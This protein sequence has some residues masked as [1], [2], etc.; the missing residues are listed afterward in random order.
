MNNMFKSLKEKLSKFFKSP[1]EKEKKVEEPV[2]KE[3]KEIKEEKV[4]EKKEPEKPVE[5]PKEEKETEEKEVKE[6]EVEEPIADKKEEKPKE[7]KEPIKETKEEVKLKEQTIEEKAQK[8]EEIKEELKQENTEE[9]EHAIEDIEKV[10]VTVKPTFFEKLRGRLGSVKLD[11]ETFNEFFEELETLLIENNVAL[12]VIDQIRND[13]EKDLVDIEIKKSEIGNEIKKFLKE[14]ISNILLEPFDIISKIKEKKDD[15]YVILFFGIN[16]S[17]KTTTISK[18]AH[19][20]KEHKISCVFAAGDTFRAASIE[21][22]AKHGENL[23]IKVISQ[24]YGTDPAAVAFDAVKY[25]KAHG[26]KAVLVDTAGRMHT[27]ADLIREMEKIIRVI[28]P[29]LKVFIAESITGSDAT[30]QAKT[31]NE[32]FGIDCSILTKADVDEKGGT[33]ISIGQITKKPILFLGTG[34]EYKDLEPFSKKEILSNL[35]LD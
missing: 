13:L 27:K 11:Q 31:F 26:L 7:E 21:Q 20:L 34:Q 18:L 12:V 5:E 28:K 15:P 35:G 33:A 22:L 1:G 19:L 16:G 9:L 17:G 30:E 23:G 29:D 2:K 14:S 3:D 8:V 10:D 32:S 6:E 25:A 4:E 24:P